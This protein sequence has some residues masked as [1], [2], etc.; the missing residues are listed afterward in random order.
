MVEVWRY[1]ISDK[2][3]IADNTGLLNCTYIDPVRPG[4]LWFS[5]WGV[6]YIYSKDT[7]IHTMYFQ[8]LCTIIGE[9]LGN[10]FQLQV[11]QVNPN[12]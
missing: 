1:S 8:V 11:G 5:E 9:Y 3:L 6:A 4:F 2:R 7:Y 12:G 10:F